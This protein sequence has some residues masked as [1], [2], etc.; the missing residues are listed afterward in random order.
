[1][2][3]SHTSTCCRARVIKNDYQCCF[4]CLKCLNP[5]QTEEMKYDIFLGGPW[6][7]YC[8]ISYKKIIKE[9]FPD[10]RIYDPEDYQGSDY[11]EMNYAVMQSSKS[12]FVMVPNFPFPLVAV[13]AGLYYAMHNHGNPAIRINNLVILWPYCVV[14]DFSKM[15][16]NHLGQVTETIEDAIARLRLLF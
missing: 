7:E 8:P 6:E 1:M 2:T 15:S 10:L 3:H 9:A 12:M 4:I 5:C 16:L 14:P 13:E 11:F